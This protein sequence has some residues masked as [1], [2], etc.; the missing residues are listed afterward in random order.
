L[1][2]EGDHYSPGSLVELDPNS[3]EVRR[4]VALGAYPDHLAVLEPSE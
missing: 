4:S 3:L 2:C 1:V